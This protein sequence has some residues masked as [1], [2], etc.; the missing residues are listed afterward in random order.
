MRI[1]VTGGAGYIGSHTCVDLLNAGY[2]IVV[3]DN[4]SNSSYEAIKRVELITGKKI[5]FYQADLLDYIALKN[6]FRGNKIDGVIHFAGLKSVGEST[7]KPLHYYSN[8]ISGTLHLCEVM[9][10]FEVNKLVFSSSATVYG[11]QEWIPLTED[12]QL[13]AANPY[14]RTKLMIEEILRDLYVS[15]KN[16][17]IA[18]LRYF[19]PIGAHKSGLIGEAP[20]GIPNNLIPYITQ[21]AV[22]KLP[23]LQVFGNDYDTH[24][25]T[26][27][28][29]YIH[30]MDLASGHIKAMINVMKTTG[31]DA[32]NLGT[33]KGYSVLQIIEA[34]EKIIGRKIPFEM[35]GRRAGDI[36][37]SYADPA[38]ARKELNWTAQKSLEEMCSDSWNWQSLNP[39]GYEE[40]SVKTMIN[41]I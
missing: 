14:G 19:N 12:L 21:V 18:L 3:V 34:F 5:S 32:Y 25:G 27:I 13:E 30:V 23:R 20:N 17:S 1:L 8:N 22:G 26:G 7:E 35:K 15:N 2:E 29:D 39:N 11:R 24:D 41:L 28:R 4:L 31:I 38:K 6:I 36:G 9:E 37:I 10:E 40:M 16:W 33:G